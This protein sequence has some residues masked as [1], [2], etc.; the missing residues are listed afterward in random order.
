MSNGGS[1]LIQPMMIG[2]VTEQ[3][4]RAGA[5]TTSRPGGRTLSLIERQTTLPTLEY[6]PVNLPVTN[7]LKVRSKP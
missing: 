5:S 7:K 2:M 3:V 4:A 1:D 6:S